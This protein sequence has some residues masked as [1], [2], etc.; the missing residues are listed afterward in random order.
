[1]N[2]PRLTITATLTFA[3]LVG[4]HASAQDEAALFAAVQNSDLAA[5]RAAL[6]AGVRTIFRGLRRTRSRH[7]TACCARRC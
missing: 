5:A 7:G 1:M 6:A 2:L 4:G 3:V